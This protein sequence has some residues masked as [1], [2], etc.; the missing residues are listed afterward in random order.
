MKIEANFQEKGVY[1]P[2]TIVRNRGG[3]EFDITYDNGGNEICVDKKFI[4][5]LGGGGGGGGG[6]V[7]PK[8][9]V[10]NVRNDRPIGT[11]Y[12]SLSSLGLTPLHIYAHHDNADMVVYLLRHGADRHA[13]S[14]DAKS[15]INVMSDHFKLALVA[16][17]ELAI[18]ELQH[19]DH[20]L[21]FHVGMLTPLIYLPLI[22]LTPYILL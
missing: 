4:R 14:Q 1:L 16:Q 6:V 19:D 8:P 11:S 20:A 2:G 10:I 3:G 13:M 7:G 18:Q 17:G 22:Y 12:T 9:D 5:M 21:W 15:F